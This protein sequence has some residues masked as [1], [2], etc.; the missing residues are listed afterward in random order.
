MLKVL[1]IIVI[2][3]PVLWTNC[4]SQSVKQLQ[5]LVPSAGLTTNGTYSL[6]QTIGEVM[7]KTTGDAFN[8]LTQ[9]FQQPTFKIHGDT[10]RFKGV[11]VYPNPA[12]EYVTV[13]II[14]DVERT[15]RID[16]LDLTGRV[17][18]SA[19]KTFRNDYW[20][21]EQYN[22]KDLVSGFYMV[23]IMSEDGLFYR[24]FRIQKI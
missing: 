18:I 23:R 3:F 10:T 11:K 21:S 12:S 17:F 7:V 6:S 24:T 20:Y 4:L 15:F 13:E 16:F 8:I 22:V 9:G 14:G 2:S 5:V 1:R 19:R